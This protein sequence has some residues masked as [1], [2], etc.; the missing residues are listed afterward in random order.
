MR[1]KVKKTKILGRSKD[2]R[3]A[4]LRNLAQDLILKEKIRT[5]LAKA[6]T[7]RPFVEPLITKARL[8]TAHA[9]RQ[10]AAVFY[11]K[12]AVENLMRKVAPRYKNRPGGY[13][14]IVKL[15]RRAKDG[16]EMAVIELV[17]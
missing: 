6:K 14:R 5:T 3:Q 7:L 13:T 10:I 16:A 1:K 9:Q 11:K 2:H 8:G 15:G 12:E 17:E 4:L